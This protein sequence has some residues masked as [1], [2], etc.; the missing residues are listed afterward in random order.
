MDMV[1]SLGFDKENDSHKERVKNTDIAR[2]V[3]KK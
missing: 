3:K 1:K 2:N